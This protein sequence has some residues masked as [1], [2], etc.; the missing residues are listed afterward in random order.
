[1]SNDFKENKIK[2]SIDAPVL[3]IPFD[4]E[5]VINSKCWVFTMGDLLFQT[6]D[7]ANPDYICYEMSITKLYFDY[8]PEYITWKQ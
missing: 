8:T 7:I 2:V 5:H 3:I 1:M 4:Q 6:Q